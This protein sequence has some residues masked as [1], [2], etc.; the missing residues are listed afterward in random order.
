VS[1]FKPGTFHG[2]P[3]EEV[4]CWCRDFRCLAYVLKTLRVWRQRGIPYKYQ[5]GP[6]DF[7]QAAQQN[8]VL[9]HARLGQLQPCLPSIPAAVWKIRYDENSLEAIWDVNNDSIIW[10]RLRE[11]WPTFRAVANRV[12]PPTELPTWEKTPF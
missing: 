6:A 8:L 1:R 12:K 5:L 9:Y 4:P 3:D 10:A 7:E 11:Y 2:L